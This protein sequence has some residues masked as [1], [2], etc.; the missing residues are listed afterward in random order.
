MTRRLQDLLR[1]QAE[2]RPDERAVVFRNRALTYAELE[3]L[4]NRLAR[5]LARAGATRGD[6]VALLVPK[7][8]KAIVGIFGALKADCAYVPLDTTSP[9]A[10]LARI[11][12]QCEPRAILF[13]RA[14]EP[15]LKELAAAGHLPAETR[16]C[17]LDQGL[18]AN[19]TW[20]EV[21]AGS[22]APADSRNT[23]SDPAHIL[24]TSGST[25]MPKG[26]VITH[27]S[28]LDFIDW[29]RAYFGTG[30]GERISG[31]PPLHFDLSTFDIYGTIST[32]AELHL[33]SPEMSLL[34][35]R[36]ADFI[37]SS[38]LTQWFSV[39]T[40]L[41]HMAKADAVRPNDF[42][43]LKRLLWCGEKFPTPAL[44]YWMERVPHAKFVNLYGPTET[45]IASSYYHVRRRP[46]RG[47][48]EIPIGAPCVGEKLLVLD[49]QL[50]PAPAGQP[51]DLYIAGVGLSPGYWRD[52]EK[53]ACVFLDHNGERI[54]KTGDLAR[55]G[56]DG[57][58][59]LLGRADTQIKSRGYRIELGEIE[60][61]LHAIRGIRDA[62]VVAV[63][64]AGFEG[65]AICCAFVATPGLEV[66]PPALRRALAR[67]LPNYMLPTRWIALD[68]LPLN[69]NGKVARTA[70]KQKFIEQAA[71]AR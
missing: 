28:V 52:P 38:Q 64:S 50:R 32:G 65:V 46:E 54:Y 60:A 14:T 13:S 66:S 47:T 68:H 49:D 10:R 33:L 11:I 55:I 20:E 4:S 3:N 17:A 37:R 40:I 23:E 56:P 69:G 48:D 6:R 62:A 22:A 44:M 45:T 21:L 1:T 39:P 53:T 59:Y 57:M 16:R 7:S 30:P 51:G 27:S 5:A 58:L 35:H 34:P 63:D 24:F 18:A 71:A 36:L 67:N 2:R 29:A 15:L 25:G 19:V 12:E 9:A 42:P 41:H 26:V 43:S 31:H 70:I 61:A 8:E